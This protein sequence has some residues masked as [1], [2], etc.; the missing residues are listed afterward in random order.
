L[1]YQDARLAKLRSQGERGK[2]GGSVQVNVKYHAGDLS[3]IWV[4]DA[5]EER[6][7][8]VEAVNRT[9]TDGL[10]LWKHRVIRAYVR[11]EMKKEVNQEALGE[12]R[13]QLHR[14]MREAFGSLKSLHSR[15]RAARWMNRRVSQLLG[16]GSAEEEMVQER[17]GK[18][19]GKNEEGKGKGKQGGEKEERGHGKREQETATQEVQEST[20]PDEEEMDLVRWYGDGLQ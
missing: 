12:A 6:Y 4:L 20:D 9:Y 8:E 11:E 1:L 3:R 16:E 7:M 15:K 5:K 17:E 19:K 18:E 2:T 10:S 13:V 14:E